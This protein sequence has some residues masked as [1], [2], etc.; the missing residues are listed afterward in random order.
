M[1]TINGFFLLFHCGAA[2]YN[3]RWRGCLT[4]RTGLTISVDDTGS[5]GGNNITVYSDL[6]L[7]S[8]SMN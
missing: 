7:I 1:I 3:S 2:S 8:P 6:D 5:K 4:F